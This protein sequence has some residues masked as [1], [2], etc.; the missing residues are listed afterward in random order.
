MLKLALPGL[1]ETIPPEHAFQRV[2]QPRIPMRIRQRVSALRLALQEALPI[3]T[4]DPVSL[5]SIAVIR[6]WEILSI[7]NVYLL[8]IVLVTIWWIE[9]TKF[10]SPDVLLTISPIPI[11]DNATLFVNGILLLM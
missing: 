3:T 4:R 11:L 6:K 2:Q 8:K 7:W 9:W 1:L 10:V 5:L